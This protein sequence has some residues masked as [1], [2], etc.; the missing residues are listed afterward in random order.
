MAL[1]VPRP[2]RSYRRQHVRPVEREL[3]ELGVRT[4]PRT[5]GE[6]IDA[7]AADDLSRTVLGKDL[8]QSFVDLKR[9]EW[10]DY[11]RHVSDWEIEQYLT[12]F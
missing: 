12:K 6:A 10:W 5:L 7:F 4:L 1:S 8:Y 11:H 2:R 9:Q 3:K